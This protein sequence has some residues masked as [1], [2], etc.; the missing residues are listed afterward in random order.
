[1]SELISFLKTELKGLKN[2]FLQSDFSFGFN[3]PT[4]TIYII[5]SNNEVFNTK[6]YV[7]RESILRRKLNKKFPSESFLFLSS[8]SIHKFEGRIIFNTL[9]EYKKLD[10]NNEI[11]YTSESSLQAFKKLDII[12]NYEKIKSLKDLMLVVEPTIDVK[13]YIDNKNSNIIYNDADENYAFAA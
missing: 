13:K 11:I 7:R 2:D 1:M 8:E 4:A 10:E 6:D 5:I 9:S 12:A 3:E